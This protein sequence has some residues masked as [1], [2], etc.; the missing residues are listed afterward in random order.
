[1]QLVKHTLMQHTKMK[2]KVNNMNIIEKIIS[3]AK[4][5]IGTCEPTGD[6]KYI[7]VYNALSGAGFNMAVAWC[8]IFVTWVMY[9]AGVA[10]SIV[11]YFASCDVGMNWFKKKG[12]WKNAKA[13]GGNYT[14]K[15]GDVIFFSG[16]YNQNDSTH[17]GIVTGVSG[18]TVHTI[19]G[20]TSDAVHE[21]SYALDNKYILGYG[22]PEYG[23]EVVTEQS[24]PTSGYDTYTVKKGDTLWGIATKYLGNGAKYKEIMTLNSLTSTTI[25][26]GLVL[27]IPGTNK[28]AESAASATQSYKVVRGDS[29]WKIA[30]KLLGNGARYK[31]IMQLSG[32]SSTTIHAGQVL[33]V[34]AA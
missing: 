29:L 33:T 21:R 23:V 9:T 18:N 20:N 16:T 6:D 12:L 11:P 19:E 5:E 17:V 25:H 1:M 22:C 14:P 34:P 13:W 7:K 26:T 27:M 28:K 3:I 10:K 15:V 8:A 2:V 30:T 24:S 4:A 31:E 32:I